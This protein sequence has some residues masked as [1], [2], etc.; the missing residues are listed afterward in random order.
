[1]ARRP[2]RARL[3]LVGLGLTLLIVAA[4]TLFPSN[5]RARPRID[6]CLVCGINGGATGAL[7]ILLFVPVGFFL[8]RLGSARLA[9]AL[10]ALLSLG[11]EGT[12]LFVPGRET[13][14]GDLLANT[15]GAALGAALAPR[16][17]AI[18]LPSRRV[19]IAA[20]FVASAAFAALL[21]AA[22]PLLDPAAP[23]GEYYGQWSPK[24]RHHAQYRGTVLVATL[25]SVPIPSRRLDGTRV[26]PLLFSGAPLSVRFVSSGPTT[27]LEPVLRIVAGRF[28]DADDGVV[29]GV[30]DRDLVIWTRTLADE[31]RL[32]RPVH[33]WN[34]AFARV[35]AG[36]T[37]DVRT[38]RVPGS[39]V[40]AAGGSGSPQLRGFTLGR[41]WSLFYAAPLRSAAWLAV[42]DHLW[43]LG[44]AVVIGWY[45]RRWPAM[46]TAVTLVALAAWR[47]PMTS[48]LLPTPISLPIAF[49]AGLVLG[50]IAR[51][52]VQE[53]TLH[54]PYAA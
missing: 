30:E 54:R 35:Q 48:D 28:G 7:N 49:A 41:S 38:W 27:S 11:I 51:R 12:Q 18:V 45:A 40:A 42:I 52:L 13:A 29:M 53:R 31:R 17:L 16:F 4:L 36:D 19:S 43:F 32:S 34:D 50:A 9:I 46:V 22:G 15:L 2:A 37:V 10:G 44:V 3:D 5:V 23:T 21:L 1:M 24:G 39:G 8:R 25:D 14:L 26:A 6:L 20:A 33:R 47:T